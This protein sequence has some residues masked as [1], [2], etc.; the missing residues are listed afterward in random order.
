MRPPLL[1]LA[2]WLVLS[3]AW[4][5][6]ARPREPVPAT[7]CAIAARMAEVYGNGRPPYQFVHQRDDVDACSYEDADDDVFLVTVVIFP[8][9]QTR[10]ET[11]DQ[12]RVNHELLPFSGGNDTA[13]VLFQP[14]VPFRKAFERI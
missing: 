8:D 6:E 10:R 9:Y 5:V 2:L 4:P 3:P 7:A 11:F 14:E 12:L 13:A 1:A